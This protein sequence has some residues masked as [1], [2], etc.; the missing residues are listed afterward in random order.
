[1]NTR[2]TSG[3]Y[4]PDRSAGV[5][6]TVRA[7]WPL[8]N[9]LLYFLGYLSVKTVVTVPASDTCRQKSSSCSSLYH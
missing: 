8:K 3:S 4:D 9:E 7:S 1:M 5:L 6:T 2:L